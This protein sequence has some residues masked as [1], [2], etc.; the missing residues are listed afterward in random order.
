MTK[1]TKNF[2]YGLLAAIIVAALYFAM[3]QVTD[4]DPAYGVELQKSDAI[5]TETVAAIDDYLETESEHVE[6]IMAVLDGTSIYEYG[7]TTRIMNGAS[8]RK[9]VLSLLYGIAIDQGLIDLDKTLAE[10]NIDENTPLTEQEKTAT[11]RDLLMARSGIYLP[12]E[13]EHDAQITDR[14]ARGSHLPGEFFFSNNFDYNALGTIFIQETG[15]PIGQFMEKYLAE[16]LGMQDFDADNVVMGDPWFMPNNGSRHEMYYMY[17]SA[18]DFARIGAMVANN[19]MWDGKQVVPA[20][21]IELSTS[22]LS[23]LTNS[24]RYTASG[25][26]WWID[27]NTNTVWTDGYGGHYML[28]DPARNLTVVMRTFSGNSY[29][30]TGLWLARSD[31]NAAHPKYMVHAYEMMIAELDARG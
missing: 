21:W 5:S 22:P 17:T 31:R 16:P 26:I 12:A 4:P 8:T 29:L 24:G 7:D 28:I 25:Y 15:Q 18:R 23:A 11:I 3:P 20:A 19:G 6:V 9:A 14:P 27:E 1:T 13:G 10:L 30:S 2:I